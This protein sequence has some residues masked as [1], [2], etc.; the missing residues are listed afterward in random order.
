VAALDLREHRAGLELALERD[1]RAGRQRRRREDVQ[2]AGVEQ[3]AVGEHLVAGRDADRR[4][5]VERVEVQ[6]LAR[7]DGALRRPRRARGVDDE[8]RRARVA[9]GVVEQLARSVEDLRE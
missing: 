7:D 2:R 8:Q 9:A 5:H 6:H 3:R 1:G 4:A